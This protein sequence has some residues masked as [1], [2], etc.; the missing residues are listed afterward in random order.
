[1]IAVCS[2]PKPVAEGVAVVRRR[3]GGGRT[4]GGYRAGTY[5]CRAVS[6]MLADL[7]RS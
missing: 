6:C 5:M 1:M 4:P 3:D 7:Q 2:L